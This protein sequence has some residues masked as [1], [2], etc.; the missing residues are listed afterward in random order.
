MFRINYRIRVAL[1]AATLVVSAGVFPVEASRL[2]HI[3]GHAL[4]KNRADYISQRQIERA[5]GGYRLFVPGV[6]KVR[7]MALKAKGGGACLIHKG[8]LLD[9]LRIDPPAAG[10]KTF[11]VNKIDIP[12]DLGLGDHICIGEGSGCETIVIKE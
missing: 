4:S 5:R 12:E 6:G 1:A 7:I 2:T 9:R 8:Y 10:P 11:V 3:D